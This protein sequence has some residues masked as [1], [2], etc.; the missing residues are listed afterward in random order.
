MLSSIIIID[1]GSQFTQLI[2]RRVRESSVY[3]EVIP[4][5]C[6]PKFP[7]DNISGII[8]SGGPSSVTKN[9]S[10]TI[11]PAVWSSNVPVLGI[12]YGMQAMVKEW[13]GIV[14]QS[15]GREF[16]HSVL[17]FK[18]SRLW[19]GLDEKQD[20]WMSHGDH[21]LKLP[22]G[23]VSIATSNQGVCAAFEHLE[24]PYWG[25]QFHP[26]VTHT[27][28]GYKIICNF[29]YEICACSSNWTIENFLEQSIVSV[30][31]QV[32]DDNIVLGLSGGVDSSVTAALLHK[33]VG[34]R[35]HC[36]FID[37]GL[38]RKNEVQ[39]VTESFKNIGMSIS[40]VDAEKL[41][42]GALSG[43][44]DPEKK[45]KIIGLEF[46]RAFEKE[47]K[48]VNAK[49]LA[50]GTIYPDI[51]ESSASSGSSHL[52]KSHHNVGGIPKGLNLKLLEP[53]KYLF[54][55]EVRKLGK[56]LGLPDYFIHRHPFPGP[57]LAIRII[58]PVTKETLRCV[59]D[60]DAIFIEELHRNYSEDGR[61]YYEHLSQA[62]SVYLPICSVGVKG[63][64]RTYEATICLRAVETVDFMTAKWYPLP[65]DFLSIVSSRIINEVHG[66]SRVVYDIS[67]KPPATIEWE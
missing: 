16:G 61:S 8:L 36:V 37:N 24:K 1:F 6:C 67:N 39:Q 52:I 31:E 59:R 28:N 34:N 38:L 14:E 5:D 53:L 4:W 35:L 29:L 63:D 43:I 45:R 23:C 15:G 40:H 48:I 54:K 25:I 21:V 64:S 13:G 49:W 22:I 30:R 65:T 7:A 51:I 11:P 41:F 32:G 9:V 19:L 20:V 55:D 58:G 44:S 3:C 62:F 42:L 12:C 46:V 33:S 10:P 18:P 56:S 2:A 50:Q 26:E 47:A 17:N 66:I 57:G 27:T 60:A